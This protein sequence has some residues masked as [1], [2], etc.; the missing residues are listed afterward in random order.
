M[1]FANIDPPRE[2]LEV[3]VFGG[4]WSQ[5]EE[6]GAVATLFWRGG[7]G[8]PDKNVIVHHIETPVRRFGIGTRLLLQLCEWA[9]KRDL[10]L[11]CVVEDPNHRGFFSRCGFVAVS[12]YAGAVEMARRPGTKGEAHSMIQTKRPEWAHRTEA[13]EPLDRVPTPE[14]LT[15]IVRPR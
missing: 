6:G 3:G 11:S 15:Q 13:F 1:K 9:D 14:E 8:S 10:T 2:M 5:A 7:P 12:N 4:H